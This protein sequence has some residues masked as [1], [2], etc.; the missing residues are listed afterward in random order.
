MDQQ[1]AIFDE[2]YSLFTTEPTESTRKRQDAMAGWI[3]DALDGFRPASV[4][5][6][7][8][9]DGSLLE[10]L[11]AAL[12][13]VSL[14]GV[15][16]APRS[17]AEA[18]RRGVAVSTGFAEALATGGADLCL[19]VNVIEHVAGPVD[20]LRSMRD[21]VSAGG[22]VAVICPDGDVPN[23][24]LLFYDHLY[25]MGR[26]ALQSLCARAGLVTLRTQKAPA[27][28]GPFHM[29]V[30]RPAHDDET[31]QPI[32]DPDDVRVAE[33]KDSY[34]VTWSRLEGILRERVD[35][36]APIVV[37]G[38]GDIAALLRLYAPAVWDRVDACAVDGRPAADR[39][40]D[41]RLRSYESLPAASVI[42][43]GV[44]PGNHEAVARR[45]TGDGHR[46]VR[47]DDVVA[48]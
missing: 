32:V 33:A 3:V 10:A 16:P 31:P 30:A 4:L 28:L 48:A 11:G 1:R 44:R 7:G 39:F 45:L 25:S 21:A 38:N 27:A 9:G 35:G 14:R 6:L 41:R 40:L 37:F 17:V 20:F 8:C 19:S 36:A 34:M 13:G 22:Q 46:V 23:Y 29:V 15:E 18:T 24:E 42:L 47:W 2:A 12:P 26:N 5:E 43:L